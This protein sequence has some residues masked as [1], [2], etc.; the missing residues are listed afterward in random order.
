MLR[1]Y[2]CIMCPQGC[3]IGVEIDEG[4]ISRIYGNKCPKGETYVTQEALCPMR[5][6]ASSVR[7]A[8]GELPLASVRLSG[9]IPKDR[10][11]DVMQEIRSVCMDAP[12]REGD[13]ALENVL[14]LGVNVI[15]TRDVE[16]S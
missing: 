9:M 6:I 10:I 11:F 12:V 3:D 4:K 15:V 7:I 5:N 1:E 13:I 16:I 14:G 2:T 8:G